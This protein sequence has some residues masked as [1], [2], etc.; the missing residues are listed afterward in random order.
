[1][2]A[3][4]DHSA[5]DLYTYCSNRVNDCVDSRGSFWESISNGFKNGVRLIL[6]QTNN[7]LVGL[8]FDT[9]GFGA[10][11]LNMYKD[12]LGVYHAKFDCWQQYFGYNNFYDFMFDIGTSMKYQKFPFKY[13]NKEY[14]F[15]AWKGNYI[16]LGAGAELGIYTGGEPH[17]FVDKSLAMEMSMALYYKGKNII[18]YDATTWWITGFNPKYLNVYA[19]QLTVT[20]RIRFKNTGMYYAFKNRHRTKWFCLDRFKT[21]SFTF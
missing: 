15:W 7:V 20:F 8:G 13:G 5:Y 14:I 21:A 16:N 10:Y 1:M 6:S 4:T 3:N 17:W 18:V 12:R 9:A 19:Y 2:G 11:W